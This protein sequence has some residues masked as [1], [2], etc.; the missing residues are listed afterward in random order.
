MTP[1]EIKNIRKSLALTQGEFADALNVTHE[2]VGYW[3][4]GARIPN[5]TSV[6][7]I[8]M[9][10]EN[11]SESIINIEEMEKLRVILNLS[12]EKFS[13][14]AGVKQQ[15]YSDWVLGNSQPSPKSVRKLVALRNKLVQEQNEK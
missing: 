8:K 6:N 15:S 4:I 11:N 1:E 7:K 5:S 10:I 13:K 14:L 12:Q 9:L 3:E 2:T